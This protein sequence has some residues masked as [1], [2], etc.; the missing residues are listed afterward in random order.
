MNQIIIQT[1]QI[2]LRALNKYSL[3]DKRFSQFYF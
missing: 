3:K 2:V 1:N